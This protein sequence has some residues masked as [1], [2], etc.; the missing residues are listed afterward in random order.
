MLGRHYFVTGARD[1]RQ[2]PEYVDD[3]VLKGRH[4]RMPQLLVTDQRMP[5]FDGLDLI[6]ATRAAGMELPAILI[7][8]FPLKRTFTIVRTRL[9]FRC[10]R[11]RSR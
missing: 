3:I 9:V 4:R 1:G 7:T 11:S 6:E 10:W 5:G 8:A 2:A